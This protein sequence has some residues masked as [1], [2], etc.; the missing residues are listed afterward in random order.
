M[1]GLIDQ[2][3]SN[4]HVKYGKTETDDIRPNQ[5]DQDTS[6]IQRMKTITLKNGL[7]KMHKRQK[8]SVIRMHKC[9]REKTA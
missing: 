4:Y 8:E 3:A 6:E 1:T 5:L 7:G 2:Y 9:S